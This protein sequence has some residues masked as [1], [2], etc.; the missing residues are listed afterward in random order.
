MSNIV[1]PP[2]N[3][4]GIC[5][6]TPSLTKSIL[7]HHVPQLTKKANKEEDAWFYMWYYR[8]GLYLPF[9]IALESMRIGMAARFGGME[10]GWLVVTT[11]KDED[12]DEPEAW[13]GREATG[14]KGD[15]WCFR[16]M[17]P[18]ENP[19]ADTPSFIIQ[20]LRYII[21][22]DS[23]FFPDYKHLMDLKWEIA[24]CTPHNQTQ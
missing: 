24:E 13:E 12:E 19:P 7:R 20:G 5:S 8:E 23:E 16:Y 14:G 17:I 3:G 4:I 21:E 18:C 10:P 1:Y 2:A 15:D 6:N 11:E 9:G 22:G